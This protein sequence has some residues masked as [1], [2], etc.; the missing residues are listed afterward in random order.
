MLHTKAQWG[1]ETYNLTIDL[2]GTATITNLRVRRQGTYCG[3]MLHDFV[4]RNFI[5]EQVLR[6]LEK[7]LT[8]A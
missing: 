6:L 3:E 8:D 5:P 2:D 7:A 4:G 1:G